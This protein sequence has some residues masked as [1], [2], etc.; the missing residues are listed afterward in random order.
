[1]RDVVVVELPLRA[2]TSFVVLL[3]RMATNIA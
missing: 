3:N 2:F 1:M